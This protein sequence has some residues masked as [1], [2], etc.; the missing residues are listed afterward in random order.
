ML[1]LCGCRIW[2]MITC[3]Q[4]RYDN[5]VRFAEVHFFCDLPIQA[6]FDVPVAV[7]TL[8]DE[9]DAYWLEQSY[10]TYRTCQKGDNNKVVVVDVKAIT[11]VIAM[12]PDTEQSAE[13]GCEMFCAVYKPGR[14]ATRLA[15][16]Q[17]QEVDD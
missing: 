14:A 6:N 3:V 16:D 12:V 4:L 5:K 17:E 8:F 11:S 2:L 13:K 9:P 15:G 10:G 7:V 1:E